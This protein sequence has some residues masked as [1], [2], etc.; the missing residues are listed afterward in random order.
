V[1]VHIPAHTPIPQINP[2]TDFI[3]IKDPAAAG[4]MIGKMRVSYEHIGYKY[5]F[6]VWL[7]IKDPETNEWGEVA[8]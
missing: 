4:T 7:E 1:I 8:P 5:A 2:D 3:M 6:D